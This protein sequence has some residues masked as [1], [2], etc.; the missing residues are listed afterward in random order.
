MTMETKR[1]I[2]LICKSEEIDLPFDVSN[3]I[4][5]C[6]LCPSCYT[7][8]DSGGVG[9]EVTGEVT[10]RDI[11]ECVVAELGKHT[12]RI[13]E[14]IAKKMDSLMDRS[15]AEV[16]RTPAITRSPPAKITIH[17]AG[18][19]AV[20]HVSEALKET[21]VSYVKADKAGNVTISLPDQDGL[22]SAEHQLKA[23]LP[24]A[25][26]M[27]SVLRQP[28]ITIKDF[29]LPLDDF[30]ADMKRDKMDSAIIE[31]IRRKNAGVRDLMDNGH[32]MA[33][34]FVGKTRERERAT[35]G[36]KVSYAIRDL[37][38]GQG[39][40]FV[41]N[42]SC[43]VEDRY[44]IPQCFQCQRFGH[45]AIDCDRALPICMFCAG[46]HMTT[47]CENRKHICCSNCKDSNDSRLRA[48][49]HTHNAGYS[50]CPVYLS[51]LRNLPKN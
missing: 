18:E 9:G 19:M 2:C 50:E 29:P 24:E 45:K 41:L 15:F 21:P 7:T 47:D 23:V 49:A 38:V 37:L 13:A 16:A 28:K 5:L 1:T 48:Q 3:H 27:K 26:R 35:I 33:V 30:P 12:D 17:N 25:A 43:R 40:L 20:K 34:V 4:G 36:L 42:V 32:S 6:W 51:R 14:Q 44:H 22:E 39:K 10:G 46:A 11:A 8:A 31:L